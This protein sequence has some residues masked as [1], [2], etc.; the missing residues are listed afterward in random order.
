ML[1][2]ESE[3]QLSK[4][5]CGMKIHTMQKCITELLCRKKIV[6]VDSH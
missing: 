4:N 1:Q 3:E 2:I 5:A 6:P